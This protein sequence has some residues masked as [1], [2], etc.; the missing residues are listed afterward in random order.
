MVGG[1]GQGQGSRLLAR[2]SWLVSW[3]AMACWAMDGLGPRRGI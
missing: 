2:S 3:R 1:S